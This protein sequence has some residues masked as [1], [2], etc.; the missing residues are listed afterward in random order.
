MDT[1]FGKAAV[2]IQRLWRLRRHI[3]SWRQYRR[4]VVIIQSL[5][6]GKCARRRCEASS[7]EVGQGDHGNDRIAELP[8]HWQTQLQWIKSIEVIEDC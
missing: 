1:R 5:W 7:D 8:A 2:L 3:K 4:K 6:R